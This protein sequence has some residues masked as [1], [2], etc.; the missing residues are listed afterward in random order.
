MQQHLS[1]Y[2][3]MHLASDPETPLASDPEMPLLGILKESIRD[4]Y[5]DICSE[6]FLVQ[7][8]IV[9]KLTQKSNNCIS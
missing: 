9:R 8:F 5:K 7:L 3:K 4:V 6:T 2:I 1:R